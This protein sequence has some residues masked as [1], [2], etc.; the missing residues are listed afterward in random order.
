[1][2]S[3]AGCVVFS[4]VWVVCFDVGLVGLAWGGF[5]N[6]RV[7]VCVVVSCGVYLWCYGLR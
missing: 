4:L 1:M 3:E 6:F 2:F 7:W 5:R